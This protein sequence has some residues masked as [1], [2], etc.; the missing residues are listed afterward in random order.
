M[1]LGVVDLTAKDT[2]GED[3]GTVEYKLIEDG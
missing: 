1:T 3:A 2:E